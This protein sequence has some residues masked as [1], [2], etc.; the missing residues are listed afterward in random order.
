MSEPGALFRGIPQIDTLLGRLAGRVD[1]KDVP[2]ALLVEAARSVVDDVRSRMA[3]GGDEQALQEFFAGNGFGDAV[4]G[5][6]RMILRRRHVAVIN[7]TGI[8]L[9]TGLGRAPLSEGAIEAAAEAARYAIV[10]VD[11]DSG[12][13][14]Q[15]ECRVAE[16]LAEVCGAEQATV[17]NNNAAAVLLALTALSQ[18][19]EV[20]VSRGELVEIGGGFRMPDVME[21]SGC[22]LREVGSTNRTYLRDFEVAVCARTGLLL[23]VHT[24]NFRV[25]GFTH[26]P[27]DREL[28]ELAHRHDLPYVNDLGSGLLRSTDLK[29]LQREPSVRDA[30]QDGADLVTFSGDKLLCGPQ[31]GLIVGRSRYVQKLR[32]HPLFRAVRPDKLQLAALEATLLEYRRQGDEFPDLPLYRAL[33]LSHAELRSR[34]EHLAVGLG[35]ITGLEVEVRDTEGFLGSGSAPARPLAGVAVAVKR[36]GHKA[37]LLAERLRRGD[38][39]VFG[40]IEDGWLLLE[41]RTIFED[42]QEALFD[43]V[44][45]ALSLPAS[46]TG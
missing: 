44:V 4:A 19:Q 41:M 37:D 2:R 10:E 24:S 16:L 46:R 25:V 11:R 33:R 35:K 9:H 23:K 21:A 32:A 45:A 8:L 26:A 20:L 27:T 38:P 1:L 31:A 13:R 22:E 12:E 18:G 42:E 30:V 3:A 28:A 17:V 15:R 7:A 40:R 14:D 43:A 5:G 29:P 34:A 6:I 36:P 39:V